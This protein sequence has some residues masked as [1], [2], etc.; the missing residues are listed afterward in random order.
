MISPWLK[1][2]PVKYS[3]FYDKIH[4]LGSDEVMTASNKEKIVKFSVKLPKMGTKLTYESG[5][6][7]TPDRNRYVLFAVPSHVPLASA[8]IPYAQGF[9]STGFTDL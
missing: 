4:T 5:T 2:G 8:S 3:K 7:Q 9:V 1:A 6:T